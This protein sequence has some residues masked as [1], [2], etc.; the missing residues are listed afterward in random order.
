MLETGRDY[1][2]EEDYDGSEGPDYHFE[3]EKKVFH[4]M[5][6]DNQLRNVKIEDGQV[7]VLDDN[8][9][10]LTAVNALKG[11]INIFKKLVDADGDEITTD[12]TCV[13]TL[14][15]SITKNGEGTRL[16][17]RLYG[18]EYTDETGAAGRSEKK[19]IS[20]SSDFTLEIRAKDWL[21]I[22]NVPAGYSYSFYEETPDDVPYEFK[23]IAGEAV[24]VNGEDVAVPA[25]GIVVSD[26]GKTLSGVS[27]S[28]AAQNIIVTNTGI[29]KK[30]IL[31]KVGISEDD[32]DGNQIDLGNVSF[33]IYEAEGPDLDQKGAVVTL[34]EGAEAQELTNLLSDDITGEFWRG[35]LPYGTYLLEEDEV[36]AEYYHIGMLRLIIAEDGV[37]LEQATPGEKDAVIEPPVKEENP[38]DTEI[39]TIKAI[40][41]KKSGSEQGTTTPDGEISLNPHKQID[42]LGDGGTD[43]D[44][45]TTAYQSDDNAKNDMYRLYL[46]MTFSNRASN[47]NI[48]FVEDWS[49]SMTNKDMGGN[50][51]RY[52]HMQE[53]LTKAG[54]FIDSVLEEGSGNH[55]TIVKFS[56]YRNT[57]NGI[58]DGTGVVL[59]WT[60]AGETEEQN[61]TIKNTVKNLINEPY[62][63]T[64][65]NS[66]GL[67]ETVGHQDQ[68]RWTNYQ[69]GIEM[70][71]QQVDA[72]PE[73]RKDKPTYVFFMSDGL[74]TVYGTSGNERGGYIPNWVY[75]TQHRWNGDNI[76]YS[77][78]FVYG[79][80]KYQNLVGQ[81]NVQGVIP[82][83]K[84][85]I[86]TFKSDEKYENLI[87]HAIGFAGNMPNDIQADDIS[88]FH[89][90]L[91]GDNYPKSRI[92]NASYNLPSTNG[93]LQYNSV[94][95]YLADERG[96]YRNAAN[97]DQLAQALKELF[98]QKPIT[99]VAISDTLSDF[100]ELYAKAPDFAVTK[101]GTML[102]VTPGADGT[103]S[104]TN[105]N[106]QVG[107]IY[108]DSQTKEVNLVF[109][110][111]LA[112]E[113]GDKYVL[114]FNVQA[115]SKAYEAYAKGKMNDI[116]S[117]GY[118]A[119][120]E[121]DTDYGE[122]LT[123]WGDTETNAGNPGFRS[124][125]KA[126]LTYIYGDDEKTE[127]YPHP[128]IQVGSTKLTIEKKWV[129]NGGVHPEGVT[130][131]KFRLWAKDPV[132]G[133]RTQIM[134]PS[135]THGLF[136]LS[137]NSD[138][139]KNWKLTIHDLNPKVLEDAGTST[140]RYEPIQ[141][142][143]EEAEVPEGYEVSYEFERTESDSPDVFT[144]MTNRYEAV[145]KHVYYISEN[146]DE[147]GGYGKIINAKSSFAI[148]VKKT[149]DEPDSTNYLAG[150]VFTLEHRE[151]SSS[152][153]MKV[154]GAFGPQ[155]DA[156]G[157]FTVPKEGV[158]L[159]NLVDGQYR[160]HELIPPK[161]Y[162]I[163]E[164][165]PVYFVVANGEITGT[166]G[167]IDTVRHSEIPAAENAEFIVPNTPG[168]ALPSTGGPG[169][170]LFTI[171]GAVL[172]AGAGL[173]LMKRRLRT[174]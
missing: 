13:F 132:T 124:N 113:N 112:Y 61:N 141:Y 106:V 120:G 70:V 94:L 19:V 150:A 77:E 122:N 164:A 140:A 90:Q 156:Q 24:D 98:E 139:E 166:E 36:P 74:P 92:S 130:E 84:G 121:K 45:L 34:G 173:L 2:F 57:H 163:T 135:D 9:T 37:T 105:G 82:A 160:L 153:W 1:Y 79:K 96:E 137:G 47:A 30:I 66:D 40:N 174:I 33:T 8:F 125:T 142:T 50:K 49:S 117:S 133:T 136:I 168:A 41:V 155:L 87:I 32:P 78:A 60:D 48:I 80:E 128:V 75:Q 101:N 88:R 59:D 14:H 172:F 102:T 62:V 169:T 7:I 73:D 143:L 39:W 119:F 107:T 154:T 31:K 158:T 108:W 35:V 123:S 51:T 159:T 44:D 170:R 15:G 52:Q 25:P 23:S 85:I 12:Q 20:N 58:A 5:L 127:Q 28:N 118:N 129:G 17:Y 134:N 145:G 138:P 167:T 95:R 22:I 162:V 157:R 116:H 27:V 171:I 110:E 54:G 86:D 93:Y 111:D 152:N 165:Y 76:N 100:V 89:T 161:G 115:S 21:R 99:N 10:T 11:G 69:A 29:G 149:D 42:Y 38:G 16:E 103:Y 81:L 131:V 97:G 83:T 65:P 56:D 71:K 18:D 64:P 43:S 151:N 3:F 144:N 91:N 109:A 126:E 147:P 26:D 146:E 46:D 55:L 148:V 53:A 104:V 6:M 67:Q 68:S 4:P 114:S 63:T 72:I